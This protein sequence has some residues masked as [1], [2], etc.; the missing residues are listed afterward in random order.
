M[1]K[2]KRKEKAR[3]EEDSDKK[4]LR[5]EITGIKLPRNSLSSPVLTVTPPPTQHHHHHQQQQP[6]RLKP[7]QHLS[8]HLKKI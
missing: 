7:S 4:A 2:K 8:S 1:K 3:K 5:S 6:Q